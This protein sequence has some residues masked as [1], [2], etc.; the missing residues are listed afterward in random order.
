MVVS[1]QVIQPGL[2]HFAY[3]L[4]FYTF[5]KENIITIARIDVLGNHP[6]SSFKPL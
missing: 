2:K 6:R 4:L 5:E 3:Q 1:S